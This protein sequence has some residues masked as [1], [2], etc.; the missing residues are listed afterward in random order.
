MI[1]LRTSSARCVLLARIPSQCI[2]DGTIAVSVDKYF[3]THAPPSISMATSSICPTVG[4]CEH[5][6]YA[7]ST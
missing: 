3:A 4:L 6:S 1:Y 5:V 2:E 7:I